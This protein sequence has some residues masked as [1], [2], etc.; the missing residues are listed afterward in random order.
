MISLRLAALALLALLA[1]SA[2]ALA[3]DPAIVALE[4]DDAYVNPRTLGPAS[5]EAEAELAAAAASLNRARQPVKL[6]IVLGPVG[7]PGMQA[8]VRRLRRTLDYEG[9]LV[10]T[11]PGR[12]VAVA[13]PLPRGTI[14]LT[15]P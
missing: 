3:T 13:G 9:T 6:A 10:V 4:R 5:A 7:A 11:A 14:T 8:Y 12:P 2:P 1:A 15:R